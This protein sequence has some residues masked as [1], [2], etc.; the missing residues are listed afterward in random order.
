[1]SIKVY[2]GVFNLIFHRLRK[3]LV[4]VK[5]AKVALNYFNILN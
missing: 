5:F 3:N 4:D 2:K 1:M